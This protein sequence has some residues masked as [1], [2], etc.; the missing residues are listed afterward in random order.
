MPQGRADH[1]QELEDAGLVRSVPCSDVVPEPLG[2]LMRIGVAIDV[3]KQAGVVGRSPV[4]LA[5]A[6]PVTHPQ[7]DHR[8]AQA[9]L[10]RLA[11]TQIGGQRERR[12][13][14][15]EPESPRGVTAGHCASLELIISSAH[16]PIE[17]KRGF[18]WK[19]SDGLGQ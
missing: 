7:R 2:L 4:A 3:G 10:H 13:E 6:D 17:T 11:T 15:R 19:P 12:H 9:V 8:L 14:L 16:P 5:D 18:F 1:A